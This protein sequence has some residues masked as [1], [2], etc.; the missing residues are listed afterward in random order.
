MTTGTSTKCIAFAGARRIASGGLEE[1]ALA[2]KAAFDQDEELFPLVFDAATSLPVELDLRGTAADVVRRL[3]AASSAMAPDV[4]N[5]PESTKNPE[6]TESPKHPARGPGRPRLGVVARE[7]TLLPRHWDWLNSQPGGAS[8][9]LRKLVEQA[10]R[11]AERPDRV[12]QAKD[13]AYRF[14]AAIA[15]NEQGFEEAARSLFSGDQKGFEARIE[16]WPQDIR[17]HLVK[18]AQGTFEAGPGET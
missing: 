7:V 3:A 4:P 2:V 8:V 5:N 16:A 9:A 10:R 15:G 12:R 17:A 18:L 1:V 13:A 6:S 11:S 14:M